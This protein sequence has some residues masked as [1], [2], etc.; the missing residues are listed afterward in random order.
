M[1]GRQSTRLNWERRSLADNDQPRSPGASYSRCDWCGQ[2]YRRWFLQRVCTNCVVAPRGAYSRRITEF[3]VWG[4]ACATC[5][6]IGFL[7]AWVMM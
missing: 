5:G 4:L 3:V 1:T 7:A 2:E 6:T